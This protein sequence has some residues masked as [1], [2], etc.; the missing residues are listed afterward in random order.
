M[1]EGDRKAL[2]QA[3]SIMQRFGKSLPTSM[4]LA[5][6]AR[7]ENVIEAELIARELEKLSIYQTPTAQQVGEFQ[8]WMNRL[9][10]KGLKEFPVTMY[11]KGE[12]GLKVRTQTTLGELLKSCKKK[13]HFIGEL[14]NAF[15]Q[16]KPRRMSFQLTTAFGRLNT[17]C[18]RAGLPR[19]RF[20]RW[21]DA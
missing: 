18:D 11:V 20:G 15:S 21:V 12:G 9:T 14:G 16:Q 7:K 6:K 4:A 13:Q 2:E 17:A 8:T 5:G 19:R 1:T 10:L 3:R